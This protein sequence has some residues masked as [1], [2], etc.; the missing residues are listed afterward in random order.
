D[1]LIGLVAVAQ[2][3]VLE[4]A[5][6]LEELRR[7]GRAFVFEH[8][9]AGSGTRLWCAA[10]HIEVARLLYPNATLPVL[11]IPEAAIL[12]ADHR[13]EARG[14]LREVLA[15]LEGFEAP[16]S[17]W[18]ANLLRARMHEYHA[19]WLD[20]L[21][22]AGEA[23]WARLTPRRATVDEEGRPRPRLAGSAATRATPMT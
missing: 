2:H 1:A 12:H 23:A 21:C 17:A 8:N 20:E 7:A 22:L 9:D 18:E 5:D 19:S 3:Y 13:E 4:W 14:G 16:A 6:W 11:A 10:E 15:R